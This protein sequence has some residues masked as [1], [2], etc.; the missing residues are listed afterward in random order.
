MYYLE[1]LILL[2]VFLLSQVIA[3]R[4]RS[5]LRHL[6]GP[7][8]ASFSNLWKIY[9]VYNGEIPQRNIALHEKYGPVVRIGPNHVSFSTLTAMKAIYNS[10]Q[11]FKKSDFY[12]PVSPVHN[13]KRLYNLF[14]AQDVEYHSKLKRTI[15]SIFSQSAVIEL[16]SKIDATLDLFLDQ[17]LKR[18]AKGSCT[19]DMSL[20]PHLFAFDAL[21]DLTL[22]H[23]FGFLES[24]TDVR[25]MIATADKIYDMTGLFGQSPLLQSLSMK[26][27]SRRAKTK[28]NPIL[29][30]SVAQAES[31]IRD[32]TYKQDM[33]NSLIEI[34]K[35]DPEKL[36]VDDV[37]GAIY[38]NLMAG[39]DVLAIT[40]RTL[41]YHL[42]RRQDVRT[43]LREELSDTEGDYQLPHHLPYSK[44]SKLTY[45]DAVVYESLRVHANT[46]VI[47]ERVVPPEG[48][49]IEG[50]WL[51]GGTIV[52]VN[53]WVI[54]RNAQVF[55]PNVDQF[56]PNR[57]L[58][59][60]ECKLVEMKRHIFS[61]GAGSRR[62]IGYNFA[63]A[64]SSKLIVEFIRRFDM[65]LIEPDKPWHIHG[66]WVTK[67]TQM[68]MSVRRR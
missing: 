5:G 49:T 30:L 8:I 68:N 61:F 37:A 52:G 36:S 59:L 32:G 56:E 7:A 38:I 20:W 24:G 12:R 53:G 9:A 41:F 11:V 35:S 33:L 1:A 57:W 13:R 34:H 44:L 62:C 22:S 48:C 28:P 54:H 19:L 21:G 3:T 66:S 40:L 58:D 64:L 10:R 17:I 31:R 63:M 23:R 2:V 50:Y 47:L 67:Q 6:P 26:I 39:H 27:K 45:L 18:T 65:T 14:S 16:E 46:G 15:G 29:Q 42:A 4:L 51:P 25:N 55:G 43:K 60:P